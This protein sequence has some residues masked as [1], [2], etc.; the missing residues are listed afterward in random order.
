MWGM[1]LFKISIKFMLPILL[2]CVSSTLVLPLDDTYQNGYANPNIEYLVQGD[3]K[4]AILVILPTT[5]TKDLKIKSRE[6]DATEFT[7]LKSTIDKRGEAKDP[8]YSTVTIKPDTDKP[9]YLQITVNSKEQV[10]YV[11]RYAHTQPVYR[12]SAVLGTF[13]LF[14][15]LFLFIFGWTIFC[16]ACR[17]TRKR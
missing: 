3:K 16:G 2:S 13:A 15:C 17:A 6:Y 7:D 9:F 1:T 11:I 4:A 10:P 8:K 14:I 12:I 5:L